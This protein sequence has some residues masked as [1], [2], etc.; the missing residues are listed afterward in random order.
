MLELLTPA[1]HFP[2]QPPSALQP[3][4]RQAK[5]L[6]LQQPQQPPLAAVPIAGAVA[7]V[8][9]TTILAPTELLKCRMQLARRSHAC[10]HCC[11]KKA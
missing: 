2:A 5:Q 10:A 6:Q 4:A 9:L 1:V 7:G 11:T 8:A 3:D